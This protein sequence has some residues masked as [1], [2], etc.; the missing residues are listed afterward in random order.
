[1]IPLQFKVNI[2]ATVGTV[3]EFMLGLN[4]KTTYEQWTSVF[5]PTSTYEGS[6]DQGSKILFVGIDEQGER[7]GMVSR[8]VENQRN[9][10]V[11]IQHY[12]LLKG[13]EE[14]TEGPEVAQWANGMEQYI[15]EEQRGTTTLTVE[16]DTAEA[17]ESYMNEHYPKALAKLKMLCEQ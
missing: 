3:Y 7:G 1:M 17:F 2:Q 10:L 4:S 11:S 5:N 12:G 8:I 9:Q 13:S 14:I 16:M 6:W 15:F